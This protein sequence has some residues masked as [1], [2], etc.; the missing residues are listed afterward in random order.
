M[1]F[2]VTDFGSYTVILGRKWLAE[3]D[4][5]LDIRNHRLVWPNE[6]TPVE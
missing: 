1:P 6:R 4:V 3:Q 5:W 2:L